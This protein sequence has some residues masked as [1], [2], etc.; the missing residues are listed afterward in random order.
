[1]SLTFNRYIGLIASD[2]GTSQGWFGDHFCE[3]QNEDKLVEWF[4]PQIRDALSSSY[5]VRVYWPYTNGDDTS[6]IRRRLKKM[7]ARVEEEVDKA[8][9]TA[10]D[11]GGVL[12]LMNPPPP[13]SHTPL[14]FMQTRR[15]RCFAV[16]GGRLR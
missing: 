12:R 14:H 16:Y 1:M 4:I 8:F 3:P 5:D 7:I 15:A 2:R 13:P 6:R 9:H 10:P 11:V